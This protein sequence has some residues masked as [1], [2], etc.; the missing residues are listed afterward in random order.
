MHQRNHRAFGPA[1]QQPPLPLPPPFLLS[2]HSPLSLHFILSSLILLWLHQH[3]GRKGI[4]QELIM[5]VYVLSGAA[6][7]K[8]VL[9]PVS[10]DRRRRQRRR[11]RHQRLAVWCRG[12]GT[13][14]KQPPCTLPLC[15]RRSWERGWGGG[16]GVRSRQLSPRRDGAVHSNMIFIKIESWMFES[17]L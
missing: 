6:R 10:E 16:G 14:I 12:G 11:G 17:C 5:S 4:I 3:Q 9:Q 8:W 7:Y 2:T 13:G 15:Y 1:E